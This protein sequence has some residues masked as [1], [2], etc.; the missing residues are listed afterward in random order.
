MENPFEEFSKQLA[1]IEGMLAQ[2]LKREEPQATLADTEQPI[3]IEKVAE[4]LGLSVSAVY[5]NKNI[6]RHKRDHRVR[7]FASEIMTYMKQGDTP[8]I[9]QPLYTSGQRRNRRKVAQNR[10]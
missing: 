5:Q 6:P 8:T 1:R 9:S 10:V 7:F 3:S 2:V 4:M